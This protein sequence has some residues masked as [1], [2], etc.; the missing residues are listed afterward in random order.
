M[1]T[2]GLGAD[3]D[4]K[5]EKVADPKWIRISSCWFRILK[6][7]DPAT[8]GLE[9]CDFGGKNKTQSFQKLFQGISF[10]IC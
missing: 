10:C 4:L 8:S 6:F 3:T 7:V 5:I 2:R 9:N 1:F